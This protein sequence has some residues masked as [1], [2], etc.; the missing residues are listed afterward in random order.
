MPPFRR[1]KRDH[2]E[3]TYAFKLQVL[4]QIEAGEKLSELGKELNIPPM[5]LC[6]WKKK[7]EHIQE[8]AA[9]STVRTPHGRRKRS[10]GSKYPELEHALLIW[11]RDMRSWTP[12]VKIDHKMAMARANL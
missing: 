10:R 8:N 5:I 7:K 9:L 2:V 3:H 4:K 1:T 11:F 12:L 6:M